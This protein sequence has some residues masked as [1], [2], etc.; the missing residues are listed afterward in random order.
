MADLRDTEA[1]QA[2]GGKEAQP[3]KSTVSGSAFLGVGVRGVS[4][5]NVLL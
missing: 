5:V 4:S 2:G 1:R 3:S